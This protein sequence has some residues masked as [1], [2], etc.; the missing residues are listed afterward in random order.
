MFVVGYEEPLG[1]G[2]GTFLD[3]MITL[4]GGKNVLAEHISGWKKP[5]LE[6]IIDL[7]PEVIV[8]QCSPGREAAAVA[9]WKT[10]MAAQPAARVIA[11]TDTDWTLPA[12]HLA[13]YTADLQQMIFADAPTH[14]VP[15]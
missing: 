5:S 9:Y 12:G 13:D 10:V 14:P 6:A 1:A 2:K 4:A 8:C 11:V 7:A 15:P 3:E